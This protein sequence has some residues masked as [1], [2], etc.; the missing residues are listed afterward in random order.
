MA[1]TSAPFR[2]ISRVNIS[3]LYLHHPTSSAIFMY[4]PCFSIS[5]RKVRL[6]VCSFLFFLLRVKFEPHRAQKLKYR[7]HRPAGA[8][9]IRA[10]VPQACLP[11][12]GLPSAFFVG[13]LK[14]VDRIRLRTQTKKNV[15]PNL[16]GQTI[17]PAM[18]P[19][20]RN[21]TYPHRTNGC[22]CCCCCSKYPQAARIGGG[23]RPA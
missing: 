16:L 4:R 11:S 17:H 15:E 23:N 6:C 12:S 9:T 18:A 2:K 10:K 7:Y 13:S 1:S 20:L 14:K 8:T 5:T 21:G 3:F 19:S 22:F